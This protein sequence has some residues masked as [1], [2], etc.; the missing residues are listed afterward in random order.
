VT[1]KIL[2]ENKMIKK[3][4][5]ISLDLARWEDIYKAYSNKKKFL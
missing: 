2:E 4:D 3:N 1:L 5:T